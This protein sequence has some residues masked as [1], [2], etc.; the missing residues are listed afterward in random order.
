MRSYRNV[1]LLNQE[2]QNRIEPINTSEIIELR[3]Q[4]TITR[5]LLK[6]LD[7]KAEALHTCEQWLAFFKHIYS[8]THRDLTKDNGFV[9]IA[10]GIESFLLKHD[11]IVIE[12]VR[13][14]L[15]MNVKDNGHEE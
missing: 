9:F 15:G 5:G 14:M 13:K 4:V 3:T 7:T 1:N 10:R 6:F 11:T 12:T 8:T 2:M